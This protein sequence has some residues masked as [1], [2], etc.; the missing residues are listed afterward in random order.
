M[1][2]IPIAGILAF[3][4]L[5]LPGRAD[6]QD[7]APIAVI[8]AERCVMC[9]QG[10]A[11]PLGLRLDSLEGLLAGSRNGPVVK[12]GDPAGSE[13]V[14]RLRGQSQPRMPLTGPPFLS[15]AE[16]ASVEKW[17]AAGAPRASAAVPAPVRPAARKPGEPVT[18]KDIQPILGA[19][20]AKC[21][22]DNG[23]M[24]APPEGY[25]LNNYA[26]TLASDARARVVPGQP[27]ASE[28]VRRI[29]GQSLPRMP[30]DGPPYLSDEESALVA[31]WIEQGARDAQGH[32]APVPVGAR[33]RLG[34][35]LSGPQQLDDLDFEWQGRRRERRASIGSRVELR[36]TLGAGG[37]IYAERVRGR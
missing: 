12:P 14:R 7:P 27:A 31:R 34:G 2:A 26:N 23:R 17:I 9:H 25:R 6:A 24:G 4:S 18:Y 3:A 32:Q 33:V 22:T 10:E 16:I 37:R 1:R 20:C 11:A 8:L 19:R 29:R 21:H 30:F 13:L 15:E 36:G 35:T 28:L 5:V